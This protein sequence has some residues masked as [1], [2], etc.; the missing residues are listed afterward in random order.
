[1]NLNMDSRERQGGHRDNPL[2]RGCHENAL[3]RSEHYEELDNTD[4]R[5]C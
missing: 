5:A 1:M 2:F 3:L 4:P